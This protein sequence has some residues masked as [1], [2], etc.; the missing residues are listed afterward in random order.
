LGWL[1]A[2]NGEQG[3]QPVAGPSGWLAV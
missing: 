2:A 3:S 1:R